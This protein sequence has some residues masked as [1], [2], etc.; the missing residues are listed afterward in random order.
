MP[1]SKGYDEAKKLNES[2]YT[3]KRRSGIWKEKQIVKLDRNLMEGHERFI[4]RPDVRHRTRVDAVDVWID[5]IDWCFK[6]NSKHFL[7]PRKPKH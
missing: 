1:D 6:H 4:I 7:I 5:S 2:V 3:L